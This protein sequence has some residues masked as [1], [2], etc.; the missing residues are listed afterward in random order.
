MKSI[1]GGKEFGR[2]EEQ[3]ESQSDRGPLKEG[4]NRYER[5][6]KQSGEICS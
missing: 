6:E 3:K 4:E 1:C 5:R 2:F